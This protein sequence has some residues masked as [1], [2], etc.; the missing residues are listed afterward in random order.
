[1]SQRM[2][3][4]LEIPASPAPLADWLCRMQST[5]AAADAGQ[6]TSKVVPDARKSWRLRFGIGSRLAIGLT[7][8]SA[9]ILIG[10]TLASQTTRKAVEAVQSMQQDAEPLARRAASVQ[11]R[12]VGYDRAVFESIAADLKYLRTVADDYVQ[13][14]RAPDLTSIDAARDA[15]AASVSDYFD[16]EPRPFRTAAALELRSQITDHVEKGRKLA[17]EHAARPSLRTYEERP[18]SWNSPPSEIGFHSRSSSPSRATDR[19]P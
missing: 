3:C 2:L 12:L 7:A 1:M 16:G 6:P 17:A 15:L 5:S 14:G 10:H 18:V 4:S 11:E 19:Y 13:A 8:V 9:V